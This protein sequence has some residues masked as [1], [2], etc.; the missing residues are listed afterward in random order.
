MNETLSPIRVGIVGLGRSGYGIHCA[1][2][3]NLPG[4]KIAAV[5]DI[6]SN[7]ALSVADELGATGFLS[8][9]ALL[10]DPTVELVVVASPNAFH[11]AHT[12]QAL[13]NGRHVVCE[14]PFGLTT[15]EVDSMMEA[16]GDRILAPFQN[17]RYEQAFQTLLEVVASNKLGPLVHVRSSWHGYGRRWDWQTLKACAGGQLNNNLSHPV[18]QILALWESL[19]WD[20][21]PEPEVWSDMRRILALGDAEDHVRLTLRVPGRSDLPTADIEFTA[22]SPFPQENWHVMA[23]WGGLSATPSRV[24]WKWID[25]TH[26]TPREATDAPTPDRSYNREDLVWNEEV[27]ECPETIMDAQRRYYNELFATVREGAPLAIPPEIARRRIRVLEIA[28][29]NAQ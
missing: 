22:A 13:H 15:H 26:L 11:C 28:R 29:E 24:R 25:P 16:R 19:G 14:K 18:D 10:D 2:L 20:G 1:T 8:I 4:W 27:R 23:T 3:R 12:V 21:T 6:D 5:A 17:R 9:D 7:R